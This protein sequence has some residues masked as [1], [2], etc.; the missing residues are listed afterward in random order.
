MTHDEINDAAQRLQEGINRII[1]ERTDL[2]GG[3]PG[4]RSVVEE[5]ANRTLGD[6]WEYMLLE[7]IGV[8]PIVA[9]TRYRGKVTL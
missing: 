7:G 1:A 3:T 6:D 8:V 4:A 5:I 2:I 9:V